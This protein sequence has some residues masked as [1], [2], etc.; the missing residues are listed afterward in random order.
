[1]S[2]TSPS[3]SNK[4]NVYRIKLNRHS[5][6]S[7][8]KSKS[9]LANNTSLLKNTPL[10]GNAKT[11]QAKL[12]SSNLKKTIKWDTYYKNI[13][14]KIEKNKYYP[15]KERKKKRAGSVSITFSINKIGQ[16]LAIS[17]NKASDWPK[18]NE[19][20]LNAVTNSAPF[21]RFP[22]GLNKN[23]LTITSKIVFD[24]N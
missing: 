21:P 2:F 11:N 13:L 23:Q 6:P 15:M 14:K 10:L 24:I 18:L 16:I 5:E 3:Q 22:V 1:M 4:F 12:E 7:F 19:A 20:A 17:I 9:A 8:N